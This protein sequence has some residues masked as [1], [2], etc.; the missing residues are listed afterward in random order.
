MSELPLHQYTNYS[1]RTLNVT[2][3]ADQAIPLFGMIYIFILFSL[4]CFQ[5]QRR[6]KWY[7][8][9]TL[10]LHRIGMISLFT[11]LIHLLFMYILSNNYYSS[12]PQSINTCSKFFRLLSITFVFAKYLMTLCIILNVSQ[13]IQNP[14]INPRYKY[15]G[16]KRRLILRNIFRSI[17][18]I[19]FLLFVLSIYGAFSGF[20]AT[21]FTINNRKYCTPT[22]T[23]SSFFWLFIDDIL[24]VIVYAC[25]FGR[26]AFDLCKL[27]VHPKQKVKYMAGD[28]SATSGYD[29]DKHYDYNKINYD[30]DDPIIQ[31]IK[32]EIYCGNPLI[33]NP[34]ITTTSTS[35]QQ[36][37]DRNKIAVIPKKKNDF[38]DLIVKIDEEDDFQLNMK[39]DSKSIKLLRQSTLIEAEELVTTE[40][41]MGLREQKRVLRLVWI[42]IVLYWISILFFI[43]Y[44]LFQS[45]F[46][47][48]IMISGT[49]IILFNDYEFGSKY[50]K[51]RRIV[52]DIFGSICCL[53][54]KTYFCNDCFCGNE[55]VYKDDFN[56]INNGEE[57]IAME[58][59]HFVR[60]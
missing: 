23:V 30:N 47:L 2:H 50:W 48:I 36:N 39:R 40:E 43:I 16:K 4:Y 53:C 27:L 18:L 26:N 55:K 9:A 46:S 31:C 17:I 22:F 42:I 56:A 34:I 51:Y 10:P 37:N 6:R 49:I 45:I 54:K 11:F 5:Y 7:S 13:I 60:L 44:G 41:L 59:K 28:L 8:I 52:C 35:I 20:N 24:L 32:Y 3:G 12:L 33:S 1:Q 25:S 15:I 21:E 58:H 57:A 14:F 29:N 38:S 19:L